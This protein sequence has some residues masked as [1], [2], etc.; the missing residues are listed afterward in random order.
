MDWS[1]AKTIL[2]I[3][4][5]ITNIVL[6]TVRLQ[7]QNRGDETRTETFAAFATEKLENFG[8]HVATELPM[9]EPVLRSL[10][11]E[12]KRL[13]PAVVK[14]NFFKD[15]AEE[16]YEPEIG[17]VLKKGTER[18]EIWKGTT[19]YY[20]NDIT[21]PRYKMETVAEAEEV[22]AEFFHNR[23]FRLK[24]WSLEYG[25]R[26]EDRFHLYYANRIMGICLEQSTL[27]VVVSPAGVI[28]M[29]WTS[30]T[31]SESG[32][33]KLHTNSAPKAALT[34]LTMPELIGKTLRS[35]EL[36][37]YLKSEGIGV[38]NQELHVFKGKTVP[39]WRV[40]FTDGTEVLLDSE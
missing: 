36:C 9:T 4:L 33:E 26:E 16:L 29:E 7:N 38:Q 28:Q 13:D 14:R 27:N 30:L 1:K 39:A 31:V 17:Y 6:G 19:L 21:Q 37:Y 12:T 18:L 3:V 32:G 25:R 15:D 34:M 10:Y 23:D 20:T 2:I 24:E 11:V 40:S 8:I 5:I 35:M 22:A